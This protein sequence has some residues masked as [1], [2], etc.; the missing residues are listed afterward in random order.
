MKNRRRV[1]QYMAPSACGS[2]DVVTTL[3][4]SWVDGTAAK[5]ARKVAL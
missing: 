2:A 3:E 5:G 1:K 4:R